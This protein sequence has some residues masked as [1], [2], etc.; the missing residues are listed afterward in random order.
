MPYTKTNSKWLQDFT[1]RHDTTK[2][3]EESLD[4]IF[5]HRTSVFLGPSPKA[6]RIK[7]NINTG[8]Q[9]RFPALS[10]QRPP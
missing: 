5:S 8:I 4:K 1:I 3:P 10:Q 7:A 6:T 9:S 2:L